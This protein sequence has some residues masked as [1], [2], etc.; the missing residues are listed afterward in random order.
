MYLYSGYWVIG[1]VTM[2]L[3]V[4]FNGNTKNTFMLSD[5]LV[6]TIT[7]FKM[8]KARLVCKEQMSVPKRAE[9]E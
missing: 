6:M 7:E 8:L 9:S 4:N 3:G 2:A 5:H 1:N